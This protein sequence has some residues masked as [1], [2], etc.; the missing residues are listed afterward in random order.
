[1]IAAVFMADS[2]SAYRDEVVVRLCGTWT[3][4]SSQEIGEWSMTWHSLICP[5]DAELSRQIS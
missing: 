4:R 3:M 1:M 5:E 2:V